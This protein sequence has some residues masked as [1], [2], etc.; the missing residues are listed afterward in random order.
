QIASELGVG[1][2]VE[3]TVQVLGERL[4]VNVQLIDAA[5]DQHR[6]A[7]RYDRTLDDAFAIQTDV[8]QQ[9][10]AALGAVLRS[11]EE[12]LIA[13]APTENAAAYRLYLQGREFH[14][15][16]GYLQ[17]NFERAQRFYEDALALDAAFALAHALLSEAHGAMQ[18]WG[19]D[20]NA[21]RVA[22]QRESAEAALRL[23]P[24]LPEAHRAMGLSHY[25]GRGDYAAALVEYDIAR[26][27]LP[28]DALLWARIGRVHRRLGNWPQVFEAC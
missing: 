20:R 7:E 22:R 6:W 4:R 17:R 9:I 25:W 18:W 28:N 26:R 21:S 3:G 2:V 19:Y 12:Q 11:T 27:G 10:V 16:P 8:A 24:D 15:A 5:T 13:N 23:A 1:S 14:R